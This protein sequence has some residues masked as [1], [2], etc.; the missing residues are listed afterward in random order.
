MFE[1]ASVLTSLISFGVK[2][3]ATLEVPWSINA[4]K[5][6]KVW[7]VNPLTGLLLGPLLTPELIS[8]ST[9]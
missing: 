4:P 1:H 7:I 9:S 5:L 2:D 6:S 3:I 8:N